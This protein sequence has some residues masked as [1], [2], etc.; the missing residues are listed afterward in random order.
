MLITL[1]Y[2]KASWNIKMTFQSAS[3]LICHSS[4]RTH[5]TYNISSKIIDVSRKL[6]TKLTNLIISWNSSSNKLNISS[7]SISKEW[8]NKHE[9]WKNTKIEKK[10]KIGKHKEQR[11][12]KHERKHD[13]KNTNIR[14]LSEWKRKKIRVFI[15]SSSEQQH[16]KTTSV[17][18]KCQIAPF[19]QKKIMS[20]LCCHLQSNPKEASI[21]L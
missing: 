8:T 5:S 14:N 7:S 6:T 3:S 2:S 9:R 12:T 18:F 15:Q 11:N 13:N 17:D 1:A 10:Q 16:M 19:T 21:N 4:P 20:N